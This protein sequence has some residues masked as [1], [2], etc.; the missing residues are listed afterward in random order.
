MNCR[1]LSGGGH[2]LEEG[3]L[4]REEGHNRKRERSYLN[5]AKSLRAVAI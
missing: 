1:P 2:G 4:S 5:M 3:A